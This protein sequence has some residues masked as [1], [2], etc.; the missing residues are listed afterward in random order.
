MSEVVEFVVESAYVHRTSY[1]GRL[2]LSHS[3]PQGVGD[4]HGSAEKW[5]EAQKEDEQRCH[6][7]GPPG[8]SGCLAVEQ[9]AALGKKPVKCYV[10]AT[11]YYWNTVS[12]TNLLYVKQHKQFDYLN[13]RKQRRKQHSEPG[14]KQR[15]FTINFLFCKRKLRSDDVVYCWANTK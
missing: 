7:A 10:N 4:R 3:P 13:C 8:L 5:G 14:Q 11:R 2:C 15:I 1:G 9:H 12:F 6:L